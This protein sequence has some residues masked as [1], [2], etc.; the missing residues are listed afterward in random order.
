[1][2]VIFL[3]DVEKVAKKHEVKE[4]K[5]GYARNFLIPKGLAKEATKE[6]LLWLETQKEIE[7]K[8]A[9]DE[10]KKFQDVASNVDDQ[11]VVIPVKINEQGGLFE[12]INA[13]K[14]CEKLKEMGFEIKKNQIELKEPIR[15]LGEFP[16][17]IRFEH[18]LEAEIKVILTE[19]K[20]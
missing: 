16:V 7:G 20:A 4:I 5:N 10:L 1:M 18:N 3:Q 8:K 2:K 9:E 11:E 14:I 6:A 12:S 17:K 15:E 19:E 13:Q